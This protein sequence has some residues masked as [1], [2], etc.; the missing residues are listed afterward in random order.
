M[1]F[2]RH[3]AIVAFG[4]GACV[5]T[6]PAQSVADRAGAPAASSRTLS[7]VPSAG[8]LPRAARIRIVL[9]TADDCRSRHASD[10]P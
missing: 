5:T 2:K 3:L 7:I 4:A 8:R 6:A 9:G 1:N 10:R